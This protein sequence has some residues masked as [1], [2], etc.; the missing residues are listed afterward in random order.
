M[1]AVVVADLDAGACAQPRQVHPSLVERRRQVVLA[2]HGDHLHGGIERQRRGQVRDRIRQGLAVV[3][4][5]P[6]I[7]HVVGANVVCA[8]GI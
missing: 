4:K 7:Q 8:R 5:V 6:S 1:S 2:A 3:A